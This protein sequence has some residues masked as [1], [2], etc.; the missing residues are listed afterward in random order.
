MRIGRWFA[1]PGLWLPRRGGDLAALLVHRFVI[2][3]GRKYAIV[4]NPRERKA[5]AMLLRTLRRKY[6][7]VSDWLCRSEINQRRS[8][9]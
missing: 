9:P 6:R 2:Y 3:D 8:E 5:K 7:R 1:K 4:T